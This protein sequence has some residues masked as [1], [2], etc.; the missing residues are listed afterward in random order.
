[1]DPIEQK[2]ERQLRERG[3]PLTA[4]EFL[5]TVLEALDGLT[6]E[7][8]PATTRNYLRSRHRGR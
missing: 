3:I 6:A 2:I 8:R 1:M 7:K 5:H 4:A